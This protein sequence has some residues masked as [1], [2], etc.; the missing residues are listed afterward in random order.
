M[1]GR[2]SAFIGAVA[3]TVAASTALA[4]AFSFAV[5]ASSWV[6]SETEHVAVLLPLVG[7]ETYLFYRLM[8]VPFGMATGVAIESLRRES[9]GSG[10]IGAGEA[11][12]DRDACEMAVDGNVGDR[13]AAVGEPGVRHGVSE[14]MSDDVVS[15]RA[16]VAFAPAGEART[17]AGEASAPNPAVPG[18]PS[19]ESRLWGYHAASGKRSD[20]SDVDRGFF[21][22][23]R[24]L[25]DTA[26]P[27]ELPV[28]LMPA[29]FLGTCMTIL[30][31][32][33]VGKEAGALQMS[34]AVASIMRR[35][36][37]VDKKQLVT[38]ASC[39][40]A[41]ALGVLLGMPLAS[42]LLSIE[43]M[44]NHSCGIRGLGVV[45]ASA[46]AG[47]GCAKLVGF[48][49]LGSAVVAGSLP[50]LAQTP[51]FLLV[52][53]GSTAAGAFFCFIVVRGRAAVAALPVP[54]WLPLVIGGT[55][56]AVMVLSLPGMRVF[57]GTG[58]DYVTAAFAG[59]VTDPY[60]LG[61][62]AFTA[63]LLAF[64]FKGGEIMPTM[65]I[66]A[67]CGCFLGDVFGIDPGFGAVVGLVA[68][69][70]A[71]AN[72]PIAAC[73]LGLE[74]FGPVGAGWFAVAAAISFFCT[75]PLS[76]Y[77]N[78]FSYREIGP[79]VRSVL[80]FLRRAK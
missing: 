61:K 6:F 20:A 35:L 62:L 67:T 69:M 39:G 48:S 10:E 56:A 37:R 8:H 13:S 74:A 4:L 2:T 55:I 19:S 46:F 33:S 49:G 31:G 21:G 73:L 63:F 76:L 15:G 11:N 18:V 23:M 72:C 26:V 71:A 5:D 54:M 42:A 14:S 38:L 68:G 1:K 24:R 44:R 9:A 65:C 12:A 58:M 77:G 32:G 34:S 47:D 28:T 60:F 16:S 25:S 43:L 3:A 70:T 22:G 80:S 57:S 40:M 64:G 30:C 75:L 45:V 7:L 78:V 52:V 53:L 59:G 36:F 79:A 27:D 17:S 41:G 66:G 51:A 29:I 50:A